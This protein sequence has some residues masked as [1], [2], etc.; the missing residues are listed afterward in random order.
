M[1]RYKSWKEIEEKYKQTVYAHQ[2]VNKFR[3]RI[4]VKH[5]LDDKSRTYPLIVKINTFLH[6]ARS[7]LQYA[8]TEAKASKKTKLYN[9]CVSKAL[10]FKEL[11]TVRDK[12]IHQYVIKTYTI[13]RADSPITTLQ[14]DPKKKKVVG[15]GKEFSMYV[16]SLDDLDSPKARN[17]DVEIETLLL[18]RIDPS[19]GNIK[20]LKIQGKSEMADKL[21]R[22][23]AVYESVEINGKKDIFELCDIYMAE[24]REFI[25][26]GQASGFIT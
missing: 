18:K 10:I 1:G 23:E 7:I 3:G 26:C 17:T 16:E 15:I 19:S 5:G 11:K 6:H 4:F 8:L 24:I 13:I 9:K 2:E 25:K 14:Y 21:K 12:D 20:K 22:N